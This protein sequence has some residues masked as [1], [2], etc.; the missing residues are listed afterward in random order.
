MSRSSASARPSPSPPMRRLTSSAMPP[1][2]TRCWP[3]SARAA[4]RR[5][6]RSRRARSWAAC[7]S[8][9]RAR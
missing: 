6:R 3:P 2:A 1:S 4:G 5:C 8:R 9:T 7:R